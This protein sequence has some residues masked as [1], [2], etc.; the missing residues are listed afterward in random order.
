ML[1]CHGKHTGQVVDVGN[2]AGIVPPGTDM[3][4]MPALESFTRCSWRIFEF[5]ICPSE[6]KR[7]RISYWVTRMLLRPPNDAYDKEI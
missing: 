7:E 4:N 3:N 1:G 5:T 6:M 2:N